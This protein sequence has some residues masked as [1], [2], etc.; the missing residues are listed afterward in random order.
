[1]PI[2][3]TKKSKAAKTAMPSEMEQGLS[4]AVSNLAS[5]G[6]DL[7]NYTRRTPLG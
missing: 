4:E 2:R 6:L 3:V 5:S 7:S 1:M